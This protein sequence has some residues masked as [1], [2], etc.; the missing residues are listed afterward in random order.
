MRGSGRSFE[1]RIEFPWHREVVSLD[2]ENSK[3]RPN[4]GLDDC[5]SVAKPPNPS[6]HQH[7]SKSA[8]KE[9]H[10]ATRWCRFASGTSR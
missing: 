8:K 2:P 10:R 9:N 3:W 4:L 7:P 6:C 5:L 1:E